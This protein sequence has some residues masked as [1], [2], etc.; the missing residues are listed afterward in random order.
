MNGDDIPDT[1]ALKRLSIADWA[2]FGART[3]PISAPW[4]SMA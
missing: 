3:S 2:R 1:T 4:W